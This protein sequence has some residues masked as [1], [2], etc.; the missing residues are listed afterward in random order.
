MTIQ[1]DS[2]PK[3][4]TYASKDPEWIKVMETELKALELNNIW[5]ISQLPPGKKVRWKWVYKVNHHSDGSIER[6]K[7]A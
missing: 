7:H 4:Y 5:E 6:L 2:E 1:S 3:S